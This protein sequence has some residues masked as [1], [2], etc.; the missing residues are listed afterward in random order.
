MNGVT[1]TLEIGAYWRRREPPN[2]LAARLVSTLILPDPPVLP[3]W[4]DLLKK[5]NDA[6]APHTSHTWVKPWSANHQYPTIYLIC[7]HAYLRGDPQPHLSGRTY[8]V[9][10][11]LERAFDYLHIRGPVRLIPASSVA[12][13]IGVPD[14]TRMTWADVFDVLY[15]QADAL[16]ICDVGGRAPGFTGGA[17]TSAFRSQFGPTLDLREA[18][19]GARGALQDLLSST[20][21]ARVVQNLTPGDDVAIACASWLI[22]SYDDILAARR[23]RI[24]TT[25][26]YAHRHRELRNALLE[27]D[28][29]TFAHAIEVSHISGQQ[30]IKIIDQ[31]E[32]LSCVSH[33][34]L[35]SLLRVLQPPRR[36]PPE[37]NPEVSKR[38]LREAATTMHWT[39]EYEESLWEKAQREFELVGA[40]RRLRL[41]EAK[42][43][44]IFSERQI[45]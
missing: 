1:A 35:D 2:E 14:G 39:A 34:Q 20:L 13:G 37:N 24:N 4:A 30:L 18:D 27:T 10:R 16:I 33:T 9:E 32:Y 22:D 5:H 41:V 38:A 43:W 31:P 15:T 7:P 6:P 44:I 19:S 11:G 36:N 12:T 8:D 21:D 25:L 29:L 45:P 23:R 26:L 28:A 40:E 42:D 17:M 3:N